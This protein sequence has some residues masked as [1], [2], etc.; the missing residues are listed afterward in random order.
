MVALVLVLG[1]G[2]GPSAAPVEAATLQWQQQLMPGLPGGKLEGVS[3]PSP[4]TCVAVGTRQL[5]TG[6]YNYQALVESWDGKTWE[7]DAAPTLASTTSSLGSVSCVSA[8]SCVAVGIA[9]NLPV[10]TTT[11]HPF[12]E[13]LTGSRWEIIATAK[14]PAGTYAALSSVS[15]SQARSCV[16][17]GNYL[18]P[19]GK[20]PTTEPA[21]AEAYNGSTWVV[22][23][24]PVIAGHSSYLSSVSCLP[25]AEPTSCA[26]V[27]SE[28][29]GSSSGPLAYH[30][31]GN[32]WQLLSIRG[33]PSSGPGLTSVSCPMPT[34]CVA[35]GSTKGGAFSAVD[36]ANKWSTAPMAKLPT[37]YAALAGISCAGNIGLCEAVGYFYGGPSA[38]ATLVEGW[39]GHRWAVQASPNVPTPDLFAVSCSSSISGVGAGCTAVGDRGSQYPLALRDPIAGVA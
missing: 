24:M 19:P 18:P 17:V 3:C 6:R 11:L 10:P 27:G 22:E 23:K 7:L 26:A 35:I 2:A 39:D 13:V 5:T 14:L 21:L 30:V 34:S 29:A 16:A 36:D 37:P 20:T 33:L 32:N 1:L 38:S 9:G 12:A 31:D 25:G 15:C 8:T 28:S 4:V